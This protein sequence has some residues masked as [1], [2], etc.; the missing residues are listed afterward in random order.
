MENGL[1]VLDVTKAA[2]FPKNYV[3]DFDG[4]GKSDF[5]IFTPGTGSWKIEQSSD[6]AY[7]ETPFGIAEDKLVT[8]DYDGDGKA[9]LAIFRPSTGTW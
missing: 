1:L 3:S 7:S 8:G 9:D 2:A 4:D 5:S 6:N